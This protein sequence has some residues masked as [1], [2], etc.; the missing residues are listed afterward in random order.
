MPAKAMSAED[1]EEQRLRMAEVAKRKRSVLFQ[2]DEKTAQ[3]ELYFSLSFKTNGGMMFDITV[4]YDS[5][6]TRHRWA[7]S[8]WPGRAHMCCHCCLSSALYMLSGLQSIP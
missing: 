4:T 8:V 1:L 2:M 7:T 6:E 5:K 3:Y